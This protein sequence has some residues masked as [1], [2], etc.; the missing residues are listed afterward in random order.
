MSR[1]VIIILIY[2]HH[3]LLD[4]IPDLTAF[5]KYVGY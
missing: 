3:K 4:L 1:K 5:Y 2:Y